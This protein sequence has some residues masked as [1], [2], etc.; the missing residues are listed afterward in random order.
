MTATILIVEDHPAVRRGLRDWL[1]G[2]FPHYR[3]IEAVSGE[4]AVD[5]T[6]TELPHAILMDIRLPGING[7][8][9]T[10]RIKAVWPTAQI[11]SL[12]LLDGDVYRAEATAAG[13]SA[14]VTKQA[15]LTELLST[16]TLLLAKTPG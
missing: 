13:A 15:A 16:L 7:L 3:V 6:K 5:L 12:T 4:E 2:A 11:V 8:E 10:R 1:E 9:A 14:Y